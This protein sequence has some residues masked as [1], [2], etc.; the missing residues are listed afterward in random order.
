MSL[1]CSQI[2]ESL[3]FSF[4]TLTTF[5]QENNLYGIK[6]NRTSSSF[7]DC[8]NRKTLYTLI[9]K[10]ESHRNCFLLYKS[11]KYCTSAGA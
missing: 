1:Y 10:I 11:I 4:I 2:L 6:Y 3:F 7:K 5:L 9:T 8:R